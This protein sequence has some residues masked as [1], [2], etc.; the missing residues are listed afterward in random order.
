MKTIQNFALIPC[1]ISLFIHPAYGIN[2]SSIKIFEYTNIR[3]YKYT[4]GEYYEM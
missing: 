2:N 1:D 3:L 4:I